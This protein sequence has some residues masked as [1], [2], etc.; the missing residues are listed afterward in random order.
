MKLQYRGVS[1][2]R[3][4]DAPNPLFIESEAIKP[5]E[6]IYR[7]VSYLKLSRQIEMNPSTPC[8]MVQMHYR[9][10]AYPRAMPLRSIETSVYAFPEQSSRH[11]A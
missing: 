2:D 11:I 8:R 9:G 10:I 7:G 5:M 3:P 4:S 6:L 1:Y